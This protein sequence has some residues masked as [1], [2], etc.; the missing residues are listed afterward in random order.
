MFGAPFE[1]PSWMEAEDVIRLADSTIYVPSHAETRKR[2][3]PVSTSDRSGN[4]LRPTTFSDIIGQEKAKALL[5]R[6]ATVAK[7]RNRPLD[8]VLLIGRSG[9]GKTTFA[10]V[11]ANELGAQVYQ[12]EAPVSM[13]TLLD[14]REVMRD[15]DILFL[16]E[17][18]QQAVQDR[19]GRQS[20]TQP[21]V[22]FSILEDRTIPTADGVLPFPHITV[23]GAT[24]DE[25]A[26]PDAMINR[27]PIRPLLVPYTEDELTLMATRNASALTMTIDPD[28][29]LM[30][31]RASRGVP[32]EV[33][34]YV[35][36]SMMLADDHITTGLASEVLHDLNGVTED[37]LTRDM[38]NTLIH[39]YKHGRRV[40]G[41]GEVTYQS[42]VATIA[43]VIGKSRD[44][45]AVQLRIE[46]VL[47]ER[48]YL[49]VGHGGRS[50][51][52]TGILRAMELSA[53][54]S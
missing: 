38:V 40:N 11:L 12:L 29:A 1:R 50:L 54:I 9:T 23:M 17:I 21:E 15:G 36:A 2:P 6:M 22:L 35:K 48:G 24:T 26:L 46:P 8:H 14:L 4:E 33:N 52:D 27:F 31:S 51:T 16:D 28:A 43:T 49:Q 13:D 10:H 47:I 25:G 5:E 34:N 18:H 30:F 42:S 7:R 45:K 32:R 20:S 44:Q 3:T 41:R 39:L 19:R 37:G 53:R